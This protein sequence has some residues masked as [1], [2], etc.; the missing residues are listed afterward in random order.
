MMATEIAKDFSRVPFVFQ[1]IL[2]LLTLQCYTDPE[3][4]VLAGDE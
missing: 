3:D 4:D 2:L 1:D